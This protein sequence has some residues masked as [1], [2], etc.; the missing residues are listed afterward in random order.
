MLTS[1]SEAVAL[2][3]DLRHGFT[4]RSLRGARVVRFGS[5]F[6][7]NAEP[8]LAE[9]MGDPI[10]RGLMARDGGSAGIAANA[11][12]RGSRPPSLNLSAGQCDCPYTL[13]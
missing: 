6:T 7:G 11:D 10:V 3:S 13:G 2:S 5:T 9:V 8:P 4:G 12:R 1:A